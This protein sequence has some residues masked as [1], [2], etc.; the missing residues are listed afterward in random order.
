MQVQARTQDNVTTILQCFVANGLTHLFHQF[1]V[2]RRGQT[3]A[4]GESCSIVGLGVPFTL[5]V[6][7]YASRSITKYS[8][9]NTQSV[10]AY[11]CTSSTSHQLLLMS[12]HGSRANESVVTSAYEQL[13]FFLQRHS[14]QHLV[15]IIS[16]QFCLRI[17]CHSHK[18]GHQPYGDLFFHTTCIV[19]GYSVRKD[20]NKREKNKRKIYFSLYF[21]AKV[22]LF[23]FCSTVFYS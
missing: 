1:R 19:L 20:T 4:N 15:N 17:H 14:L 23:L 18:Q 3:C 12:H 8:G 9:G 7:V 2:P 6:N 5:G 16:S 11:R 22:I 10:N 21:R 13:C